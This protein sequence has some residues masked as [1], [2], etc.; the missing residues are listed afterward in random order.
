MN[1]FIDARTI[2]SG[3][4]I[5]TDILIIGGGPAGITL[6]LAL[7]DAPVKV[8]LLESGGME[9]DAATQALYAGPETGTRYLP[10]DASRMRFF[11]GSTNHWGGWCR[12]LEKI[13]FE[14]R[15]WLAH[16]GWPFGR[17]VLEAYF[18]RAQELVEAGPF[19]YDDAPQKFPVS[20]L[21]MGAGGI[22]TVW[23][24]FSK[25]RGSV[26]PTHFG[27]RYADDLKQVSNL[28]LYT[29]ANVTG[30]RLAKDGKSLN[31]VDVATLSG[32]KFSVTPRMVVLGAGAIEN[33]RLLLASNDVMAAG[34]GNANDLVGR[35]FSDH[36]IPGN[37]ATLVSFAGKLSPFYLGTQHAGGAYVRAA[38][39]PTQAFRRS[40][41]V[42][43][44][45]I[46]V[47]GGA[48][49]DMLGQAAVETAAE[50]LGIDARN[51][52]AYTIG[53]GFEPAPDPDRRIELDHRTR[54]L[55]NAARETQQHTCRMKI[56][57]AIAP[58]WKNGAGNCWL[59]ALACCASAMRHGPNGSRASTG[60]TTT[61]APR[62]CTPIP[63]RAWWMPIRPGA[64]H[65]QS[66]RGGQRVVPDL[67]RLEP[68]DEPCGADLAAG[69][70]SERNFQ[71]SVTRRPL[72]LSALALIG[73][74]IA[75]GI[76]VEAPRL[77]RKRINSPYDDITDQLLDQ[78]KAAQCRR[79][80]GHETRRVRRGQFGQRIAH[81]Q[82]NA[83]RH[84]EGRYCGRS[85]ARSERMASAA[86]AGAG[87]RNTGRSDASARDRP[88]SVRATNFRGNIS[89]L[90]DRQA[91]VCVLR[92][93]HSPAIPAAGNHSANLP[94]AVA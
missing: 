27:E 33:A 14:K 4:A 13:D 62:G 40:R 22:E 57:R 1:S 11:G 41:H 64:W 56:S 19:I 77:L 5:E 76:A 8:T 58:R 84:G 42:L 9:F 28:K 32:V 67:W 6:A 2:P 53:C 63:N 7:K 54:R 3:T 44:S 23:F 55:G 65:R 86:I 37:N 61:W 94:I 90:R 35:Y 16:S 80:G 25:M 39:A 74:G 89:P 50:T 34:I 36:P 47:D 92:T 75:G 18:P 72:V 70:S 29:N 83:C 73:V 71:M 10:L 38:F 52:H 48:K 15:D 31:R 60:A 88:G 93:C 85:H 91:S 26:L 66:V 46:T 82:R 78:E 49:L 69:R 87:L 20:T 51:A 68:D 12:P 21:E 17:E 59:P 45:L 81:A 43:G 30:L 79:C 24:Q